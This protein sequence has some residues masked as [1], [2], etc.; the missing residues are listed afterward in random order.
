[1]TR[2]ATPTA[3]PALL[4]AALF[5]A[6]V[7]VSCSGQGP[8]ASARPTLEAGLQGEIV[9]E[10]DFSDPDSGWDEADFEDEVGFSRASYERGGFRQVTTGEVWTPAPVDA[11]PERAAAAVDV[12]LNDARL[13]TVGLHW[14]SSPTE[15]YD[16]SVDL[17][18]GDVFIGRVEGEDITELAQEE[19]AV[20][21]QADQNNRVLSTFGVTDDGE[22]EITCWVNGELVLEAADPEALEV[23]RSQLYTGVRGDPERENPADVLYDNYRL[24]NVAG[25]S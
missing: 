15:G 8:T 3:R 17:T 25:G 10:D 12:R 24:M 23:D 2:T 4:A 14:A 11:I 19:E 13:S 1:M 6:A 18:Y 22:A 20:N 9:F 5:A 16:C 21:V 7:L